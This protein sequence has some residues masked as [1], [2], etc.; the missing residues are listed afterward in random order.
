M[1]AASVAVRRPPRDAGKLGSF[2]PL[3]FFEIGVAGELP[4]LV[5]CRPQWVAFTHERTQEMNVELFIELLILVVR[6][7]SAGQA[8]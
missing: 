8:W 4:T 1:P 7:L 3:D 5:V 2:C 6:V